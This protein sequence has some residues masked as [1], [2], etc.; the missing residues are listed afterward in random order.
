[1]AAELGGAFELRRALAIGL[2][3]LVWGAAEP[4]RTLRA[5]ASLYLREEVQAEALVR[6]TADPA[7]CLDAQKDRSARPSVRRSRS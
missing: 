5:Y 4:E 7:C 3:P 2:V 1:M 6:A